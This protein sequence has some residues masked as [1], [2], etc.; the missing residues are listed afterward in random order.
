MS[1]K[2][3]SRQKKKYPSGIMNDKS[4]CESLIFQDLNNTLDDNNTLHA[5]MEKMTYRA[6]M[7]NCAETVF[8]NAN[9]YY[10][11]EL[12]Y[13]IQS[14]LFKI[15]N[16]Y[17]ENNLYAQFKL[18][19]SLLKLQ[20]EELKSN[21]KLYKIESYNT[22]NSIINTN[23]K[24][25][26]NIISNKTQ[27]QTQLDKLYDNQQ[28]LQQNLNNLYNQQQLQQNLNNLYD[29]QQQLQQNLNNLYDN[30]QQKFQ[31]DSGN[32]TKS[33]NLF[34]IQEQIY[35]RFQILNNQNDLFKQRLINII[36]NQFKY[37]ID[38]QITSQYINKVCGLDYTNTDINK[39]HVL[40]AYI[41]CKMFNN[42]KLCSEIIEIYKDLTLYYNI[43]SFYGDI[44]KV[45]VNNEGEF[46]SKSIQ[47]IIEN[48]EKEI[49][50][51]FVVD[52]PTQIEE[53]IYTKI[54]SYLGIKNNNEK[55]TKKLDNINNPQLIQN[56]EQRIDRQYNTILEKVIKLYYVPISTEHTFDDTNML[57][58]EKTLF[59]ITNTSIFNRNIFDKNI[60][61]NYYDTSM[62]IYTHHLIP[63][64]KSNDDGNGRLSEFLLST[65]YHDYGT[66]CYIGN[67]V[68]LEISNNDNKYYGIV[69]NDNKFCAL[70]IRRLNYL[71]INYFCK[72][73][74]FTKRHL[75]LND[76]SC[77]LYFNRGY[78]LFADVY[79]KIHIDVDNILVELKDHIT[80]DFIE[81]L[82]N[83]LES[84]N[85]TDNINDDLEIIY[86][87]INLINHFV[88]IFAPLQPLSKYYSTMENKNYDINRLWYNKNLNIYSDAIDVNND[89]GGDLYCVDN[90]NF[91]LLDS[92]RYKNFDD[93]HK[94]K[95]I[96]QSW[97]YMNMYIKPLCYLQNI[98]SKNNGIY[99]LYENYYIGFVNPLRNELAIYDYNKISNMLNSA[100]Y[101][102]NE[103]YSNYLQ[104]DYIF[105]NS[106]IND[107]VNS[108]DT[109]NNI[110]WNQKIADT[111][112]INQ[113]I[114]ISSFD[115]SSAD[116]KRLDNLFCRNVHSEICSSYRSIVK[117]NCC[118]QKYNSNMCERY[119]DYDHS[120]FDRPC[121]RNYTEKNTNSQRNK[122]I[123]KSKNY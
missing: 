74:I 29:N 38:L 23:N 120:I 47:N 49:S 60:L 4:V 85:T 61:D 36:F 54:L 102:Q 12:P 3:D 117:E 44:L 11:G 28:Q 6:S 73:G 5:T 100:E 71:Y 8:N 14:K 63:P 119:K 1:E 16:A 105:A 103:K 15:L 78:N 17:N 9:T 13:R 42:D 21:M 64:I 37:D 51:N 91:Y 34:D 65:V 111:K 93:C 56:L 106:S 66:K 84:N 26:I 109:I 58:N 67:N 77:K 24:S 45:D 50:P 25:L 33:S 112:Y 116:I 48:I 57:N 69:N 70:N 113:Q 101:N 27:I 110:K 114:E 87:L 99:K 62:L 46:T 19:S 94:M 2:T 108:I 81:Q 68:L 122:K 40:I 95:T 79:N 10:Y 118:S 22:R 18:F 55:I 41:L 98:Q 39:I 7:F 35:Q 97:M 30:I 72:D 52:Q 107:I 43:H 104:N 88:I 90:K 89:S 123:K 75:Y 86:K 82:F 96:I 20:S 121:K 115:K 80:K 59:N 76:P 92:K 31:D 53:D 83:Y 32:H